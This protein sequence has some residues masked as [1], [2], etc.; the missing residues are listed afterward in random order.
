MTNP[1]APHLL[2]E[3]H[4]PVRIVTINHPESHNAI[5]VHLHRAFSEVWLHLARDPE[6]R[7]VVLT[8]AGNAFSAGGDM[9]MIQTMW[10]DPPGR[11]IL[12][13]EARRI[14][15]EQVQFPLPTIAAVNG[16]AV[17][18]G[19]SLAVMCDVVY[20]ADSAYLADPHAAVGLT[21]GDGG[22][23]AWPLLTSILRAKEFLLT[24]D[25]IPAATAVSLGFANRSVDRDQLM[26]EAIALAEKIAAGHPDHKAGHKPPPPARR[27]QRARLRLR[28][29]ARLLRHPRA[30]R[31]RP[32]VPRQG[33]TA[34][35]GVQRCKR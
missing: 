1:F 35:S 19:C 23:V 25:R 16:P 2:I 7:A 22:A 21:A 32:N 5:D 30:P 10:D 8:G 11:R 17:G 20:M 29:R 26:P 15:R 9:S 14:V 34:R 3:S 6:A 28:G 31:D 24:G 33:V 4:G 27:R 18:L 13:D 12:L